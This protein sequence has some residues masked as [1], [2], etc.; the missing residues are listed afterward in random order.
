MGI[1]YALIGVAISVIGG[2]IGS[3]MGVGYV[4]SAVAGL[5]SKKPDSF[6][7][8]L[9][10]AALPTT[11]ALYGVLFGFVILIQTNLLAGEPYPVSDEQGFGF[12]AAGAIMGIAGLV[13]GIIQGKVGQTGVKILA[14]QPE[15]SSQAIVLSALVETMAVFALVI[16]LIIAFVGITIEPEATTSLVKGLF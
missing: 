10:L 15:N 1:V 11:Q 9:A 4:G 13:S 14:E 3:S 5:L 6:G 2:A 12:M 7:Q 16:A 8:G